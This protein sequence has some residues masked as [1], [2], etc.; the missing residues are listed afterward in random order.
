MTNKDMD[1]LYYTNYGQMNQTRI[2]RDIYD[3]LDTD[4]DRQGLEST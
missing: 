2:T 1:V 4:Y 3:S